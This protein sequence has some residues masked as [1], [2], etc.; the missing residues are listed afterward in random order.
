MRT[1]PFYPNLLQ[2]CHRQG[3]SNMDK[4]RVPPVARARRFRRLV[5]LLLAVTMAWAAWVAWQ[6]R[7]RPLVTHLAY[8]SQTQNPRA[9]ATT[10]EN[11][12]HGKN[13]K[14]SKQP[15]WAQLSPDQQN[16]LRPLEHEWDE[17][18]GPER[19]HLLTA[20]KRFPTMSKQ[21]QERYASRLLQWSKMTIEQ[22]NQARKRYA[23]YSRVQ[24]EAQLEIE[25]KWKAQQAEIMHTTQD[26]AE[27]LT[28][29]LQ[30]GDASS[31]DGN[32]T[33]IQ[34]H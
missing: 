34:T 7:P 26:K 2:V 23:E 4:E 6:T 30:F 31:A 29:K 11:T 19:K 28:P 13:R 9:V 1:P 18:S 14:L 32:Q 24:K 20:A 3:L 5:T 15:T 16:L 25:N 21:K 8:Q 10:A 27:A 17:L 33:G 12:A 22:R